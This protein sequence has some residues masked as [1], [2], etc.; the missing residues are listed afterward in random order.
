MKSTP[1]FVDEVEYGAKNGVDS[2]CTLRKMF[3][4]ALKNADYS[5]KTNDH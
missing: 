3:K 5:E 1:C 4:T 2:C